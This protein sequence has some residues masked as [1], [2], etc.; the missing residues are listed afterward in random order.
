MATEIM[1]TERK[2]EA[3]PGARLP[4]LGHL[5]EVAA[6]AGPEEQV[7]QAKYFDTD[8]LRLIR[9]GITLRRRQ[10]GSDSGWHLKLPAGGDSRRE[11]QLP[12]GRATR[13]VPA[14]LA[15]LVRAFARGAA[16][17][18]VAEIS[19]VRQRLVLLGEGGSSLAEVVAD[20]VSASTMGDAAALSRW[21][22]VEVELTG[23]G[24]R[25]LAAADKRLRHGGLRSA[26]RQAKLERALASQLP[27]PDG[28]R[29]PSALSTAAEVVLAYAGTQ[30]AAIMSLDPL[31]RRDAPDSVHQMRVATRRL[32]STLKSFG[33]VLQAKDLE[34]VGEELKW[35][36]DVLGAARDAEVLAGHVQA[37]LDRLPPELIMG[38]AQARVRVH[39]APIKAEARA[40]VLE[41]LDSD[42]YLALL[43]SLDTLLIDPPLAP[44]AGQPAAEVLPAAVRRA[45]RRLR[46]RMG[47]ALGSPAGPGRD[48]AL[49]E[50]RK[51]AKHAR[52]AAEAASPAF[53]KQARR[54]AKLV[55]KV[56]SVLGDHHD[57]VVTRATVRDL[58][59]QA[60]LA[61]E[62]AFTFG[63]LYEQDA[64]R[65]RDLEAQAHRAW[66][67]A[68]RPAIG[69][70]LG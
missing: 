18:P 38:P 51:A 4:D 1:E 21:Q 63:V 23:G 43:D 60:H 13:Q 36:G 62:N 57:G 8:D 68:C 35:L 52:Y 59:V 37:D 47:R 61:G 10:G 14:E 66:K 67:R 34:R 29:P 69:R 3:Q 20:D 24:P 56:Q 44:E 6:V 30:V 48:T 54:F 9:R 53:G 27:P 19:T 16:L 5:P 46:R 45:R 15:A 26:G 64:C 49:H 12:L 31:V 41:A 11:I 50:A 2:Y 22:E 32:R 42:R 70:W 55:K 25:L 17:R 40:A 65:A 7:L 28:R 39:F 33:Q 58:G